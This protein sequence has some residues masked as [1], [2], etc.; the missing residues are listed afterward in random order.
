LVPADKR[1]H[2]V[3]HLVSVAIGALLVAALLDLLPEA[4]ESAGIERAG[5]VGLTLLGLLIFFVL[6]KLVLW[7]HCHHEECEAH[8][9][10]EPLL[11]RMQPLGHA[12]VPHHVHNP[13]W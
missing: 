10:E 12:R 13:C 6:E 5:Q 8:P 3:P 4:I 2:W 7:R 9:L 11:G 1:V